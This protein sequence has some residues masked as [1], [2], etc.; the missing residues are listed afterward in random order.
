MVSS[1]ATTG[2]PPES[3]PEGDIDMARVDGEDT[4]K[5]SGEEFEET[6]TS[7]DKYFIVKSLTLQDLELSV[8]NGIWA[9]Q[10]HNEESLNKAFEVL[11]PYQEMSPLG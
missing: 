3:A 7:R 10:S 8:H 4:T 2:A 9:T 1:Q 5:K 11:S 6:S